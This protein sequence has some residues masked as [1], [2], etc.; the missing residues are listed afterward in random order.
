MRNTL[1]DD[2][3]AWRSRI[4]I[5]LALFHFALILLFDFMAIYAP[6]VMSR[7]A[8]PG[9]AFTIGLVFAIGIV[10]SIITATFYY[11]HRL[12]RKEMEMQEGAK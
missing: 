10:F 6:S 1:H 12:N 7:A 5:R 11:T 4:T 3:L 9:S 8:W 2:Y